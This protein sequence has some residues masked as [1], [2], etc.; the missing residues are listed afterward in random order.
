MARSRRVRTNHEES[1]VFD[2][3]AVTLTEARIEQARRLVLNG[4]L[5]TDESGR[6]S[7]RDL[8]CRGL[9]LVINDKTG[10]TVYYFVGKVGGKS[11]R[12]SLGDADAVR[13]AEA[14]AA[15]GRLRFDRSLTS[16]LAPRPAED[17]A[18][19]QD[20]A[21]TVGATADAM[22]DA[23][24]A[25]RWLPGSRT[26][27]PTARTMK[28]YRD[29]RR[30]QLTAHNAM[31]LKAFAQQLPAIYAELQ[32]AAPIQ[33]NRW[34]QLMRNLFGYATDAG[35]WHGP[36]PAIG[37]SKADR[38]TRTTE[39]HRER[40]LTDAEWRRLDKAMTADLPLWRHLFATS[41]LTLQR[42]GAVCNMR[43][44]DLT[45]TG[46]DACWRIPAEWMKGRRSGHVV[47]L[48]HC[49][50][51]L[52]ILKARRKMV[53]KNCPFVFPNPD[54]GPVRNYDKA[55]DRIIR[56]A[57]LWHEEK[58][59]RPR[60]HDLRRTGGSRMTSAGVPLGVVTRA[61]GNSPSSVSMVSRVYAQVAD[62]TLKD[63][64][65]ATAKRR[66]RR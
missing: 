56:A 25:G 52:E 33:A 3:P 2:G 28:F 9:V 45:L 7:W 22:L 21:Q 48:A 30:A 43:W 24:E 6:R 4:Q 40:V 13:L 12:R 31:P 62:D 10:S 37:T 58:D 46:K 17:D 60:P 11:V 41:M 39:R 19:D 49:R 59:R 55:W 34:L 15:V 32:A 54:G 35:L 57:G 51:A 18:D 61:L 53:P 42:M 36:N 50:E 63:A 27:I 14:R 23:H 29:L 44:D 5:D 47:P 66:P 38:L 20:N 16:V 8:E 65:A 64:F 26:R 1:G